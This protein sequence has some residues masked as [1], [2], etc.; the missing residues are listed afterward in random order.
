MAPKQISRARFI[1]QNLES[2][3]QLVYTTDIQHSSYE[4]RINELHGR[5][6]SGCF[7]GWV[8]LSDHYDNV[9]WFLWN[10]LT[11]KL[12]RLPP[13]T[14]KEKD[15]YECC[16]S[17]P[18]D[19]QASVFLLFSDTTPTIAFCR[20]DRKRK[21]LKWTQMSY[22]KQLRSISG[23]DDCFL[24][25]PTCCNGKVFAMSW[26]YDHLVIQLDIVVKGKDV[27]INLL[28]FVEI[29]HT[30]IN[31][32]PSHN[33]FKNRRP[34][35]KGS[36]TKLFFILVSFKD[37]ARKMIVDVYLFKL[38]MTSMMWKEIID[39]EDA[40][41]FLELTDDYS[42]C[43]Y[44][45]ALDSGSGGYIHILGESGKTICS[46]RPKDRSVTLSSLSCLV[47]EKQAYSWAMLDWRLEVDHAKSK[48]EEEDKDSKIVDK[49]DFDNTTGESQLLNMPLHLMSLI[50]DQCI[51]A[52]YIRFRATCKECSLAA[53]L[54]KW[55]NKTTLGR[56]KKYSLA[57]P[58]LMVLDNC[59]DTITFIDPICGDRY[60]I[61]TP[62]ELK[63]GYQICCSRY[64]WLLMFIANIEYRLVF[65][66]PF[67]G[68]IIELPFVPFLDFFCFS[69]PPTSPDCMVAGFTTFG[70]EHLYIHSVSSESIWRKY[71]LDF[72]NND[73]H[74]YHFPTFS[75]RDI[76]ALCN[77]ETT[78]VF[79]DI[80]ADDDYSWEVVIDKGPRS[81][82]MGYST[83]YFSTKCDQDLLLVTVGEFGESVEVF[84]LNESIEEWEKIDTL[85]KHMIYIS[86]TSCICLEAKSP[87]MENKI[88]FP[89]LLH[90]EDTKIVLY[91]LETCRYHTFDDQQGFGADLFTTK[92]LCHPHTWIEPSWS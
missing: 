23:E 49:I 16:L 90:G 71:T 43:Y 55:S 1:A 20:L 30:P 92:Y 85:G 24:Q 72:G 29:P 6:I 69:A 68:N 35:I 39:L 52:E 5:R 56:L 12:I 87:K 61:K 73:P 83:Q 80:T 58:W 57:S 44:S 48:Q 11:S 65:F 42:T 77:N 10:P 4:C 75:G 34:L 7:H 28:P 64:G 13:L 26:N 70:P 51:G 81:R 62:Q 14:P 3:T 79:K 78:E 45:C 15:S 84:K 66:N 19:D 59:R 86:D 76:Y 31:R 38:D 47:Q 32:C 91:S 89:R 18:P 50:M 88:Y 21:R 22:A 60:F 8:I 9:L 37:E 67:T 53:P 41:F 36:C 40:I 27:V 82:C 25:S 33:S 17:S 54:I 63:G 46:F 74:S 2:N